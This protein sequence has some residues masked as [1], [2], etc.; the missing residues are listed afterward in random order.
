MTA[1]QFKKEKK[2]RIYLFSPVFLVL[3]VM[4]T[5]SGAIYI[6]Y[7]ISFEEFMPIL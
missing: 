7:M 5:I 3:C 6:A 2:N 4:D 1:H